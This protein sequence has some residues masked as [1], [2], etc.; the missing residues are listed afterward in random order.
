MKIYKLIVLSMAFSGLLMIISMAQAQ[1]YGWTDE[2]GNVRFAD[3]FSQV[4]VKYKKS[5]VPV[6]PSKER[7][8]ELR[9]EIGVRS[10]L[11][12]LSFLVKKAEKGRVFTICLLLKEFFV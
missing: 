3:E 8:E 5:A 11:L 7:L 9:Q 1:V 4:P 2:N 12:A 6:G 10:I